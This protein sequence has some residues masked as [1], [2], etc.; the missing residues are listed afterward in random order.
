[1]GSRALIRGKRHFGRQIN[2]KITTYFNPCTARKAIGSSIIEKE[3]MIQGHLM[4]T[5]FGKFVPLGLRELSHSLEDN[6][7]IGTQQGDRKEKEEAQTKEKVK[8]KDLQVDPPKG[9]EYINRSE[10]SFFRSESH[11]S[12]S[13]LN[14]NS[15]IQ[16]HMHEYYL[17]FYFIFYLC[18]MGRNEFDIDLHHWKGNF[19]S[20]VRH[21]WHGMKLLWTD[22]RISSKLLLKLINGKELSRREQRQ[23]TR[24][25]SDILKLV[26][27]AVFVIVPFM[28]FL[29]P[30]LLKLFPNM[31]P[32]TFNGEMQSKVSF[33]VV[34]L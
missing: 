1:M 11:I 28:E 16:Y 34:W 18:C 23:L 6:L 13:L 22:T 21:Y 25:T 20:A 24:T 29:I 27:F 32:S 12:F 15:N 3:L 33:Y 9:S 5:K 10:F 30:V 31:L 8:E 17:L 4:R 19:I 7:Q 26:P 14:L 2:D